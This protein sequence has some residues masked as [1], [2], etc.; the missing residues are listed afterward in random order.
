MLTRRA[1]VIGA[2]GE[3]TPE[4]AALVGVQADVASYERL[5]MSPHGG[6]WSRSEITQLWH[7]ADAN[8]LVRELQSLQVDYS[9]TIFCGHG[10]HFQGTPVIW[11]N[12]KQT[13]Y[14]RDF[15]TAAPRQ[16]TIIDACQKEAAPRILLD[17]REKVGGLGA[18][19]D[20]YTVSCRTAYDAAIM[21][22]GE[23][24]AIMWG[25][26]A[27]QVAGENPEGGYFSQTL[28]NTCETWAR[29]TRGFNSVCTQTRNI[30]E[31]MDAVWPKVHREHF[32]QKPWA[33]TGRDRH[34]FPFVVA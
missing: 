29:G 8:T 24:T 13:I 10:A 30:R 23:M 31:V 27:E 25:C 16:L 11:V 5:L 18:P 32:P 34:A 33:E 9:I 7:P 19:P 26:S 6:A 14:V 2:P 3:T 20:P 4:E 21:G 17:H 1:I 22:V 28:I 12:P 15:R